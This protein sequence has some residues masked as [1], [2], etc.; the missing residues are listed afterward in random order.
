MKNKLSLAALALSLIALSASHFPRAAVQ[1]QKST[2]VV[3]STFDRVIRTN[4]L[5]CGY[6][7]ATPWFYI[8]P[9]TGEKKGYAH[10]VTEAVAKKMGVTIEWTE[11]VGWGTAEQG[12]PNRY[13]MMCGTVC[14][15]PH[16]NRAAIYSTP[17]K[18]APM[19]P[20]VRVDDHRF[21]S[22]VAAINDPSVRIGVKNN[23]VFEYIA[24]EKYPKATLVYANDI[25]DDTD[26]L[27]ML[28][29]NKIDVALSGKITVDL[30]EKEHPGK[31]KALPFPARFCDGAFMM[32][33]GE[34]NMKQ[35]IDN[36]LLELNT[37]G[38]LDDIVTKYMPL[39][40]L[41]VRLPAKPYR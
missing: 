16:R 21:D 6:A 37:A 39:D 20:I 17:F 32:P 11:E 40:P 25:S 38:V 18:H 9:K 33:L 31:I 30:Y 19:L 34:F 35:M 24:K 15:D 28:E 27:L 4:T 10:D 41:Y 5:R 14:V 1:E 23:H 2:P 29:T 36:A 3:E 12:L 8:D 7:V 22:G 13:D 26:F